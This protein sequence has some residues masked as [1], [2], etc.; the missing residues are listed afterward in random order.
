MIEKSYLE[1]PLSK[2]TSNILKRRIR[3]LRIALRGANIGMTKQFLNIS[4]ICTILE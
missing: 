1:Y 4:N 3:H 2:R